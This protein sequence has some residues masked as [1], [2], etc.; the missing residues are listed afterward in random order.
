MAE[1]KIKSG[2]RG[3]LILVAFYIFQMP[4]MFI[5]GLFDLS[6]VIIKPYN[7]FFKSPSLFLLENSSNIEIIILSIILI[8]NI[9]IIFL[10]VKTKKTFPT[11]FKYFLLFHL[12]SLLILETYYKILNIESYVV[13][14][15]Q[16]KI[17]FF[18]EAIYAFILAWYITVSKRVK[19][20]FIN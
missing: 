6:E 17:K 19:V 1:K 9:Y 2:L 7:I 12:G 8:L 18:K 3:W 15:V 4:V 16:F 14:D 10:F 5:V 13:F 11:F 20:T